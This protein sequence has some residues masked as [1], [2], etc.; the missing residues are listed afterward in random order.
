MPNYA[1]YEYFLSATLLVSA[2]FGMGTS[3]TPTDFLAVA[4]SPQ[5]VLLILG[6]QVLLTPLLVMGLAKAFFLPTEIVIGLFVAAALPGGLFSNIYTFLGKGNVAL[7]VAATALCTL[8]CLFTTTFV[9]RVFAAQ[10]LPDTFQMPTRDILFEIGIC[11]LLPMLA[12]MI[13][14]RWFP[15][16]AASVAKFC[17]RASVVLLL[18]V[19]AAALSGGKIDVTDFGLRVP[20]AIILLQ[21]CL[22]WSSYG[23][24]KLLRLSLNDTFT[25]AIEVLVRNSHLGVLLK[26]ALFPADVAANDAIGGAV[27]YAVLFYGFVCMVV[28]AGEVVGK[29]RFWGVYAKLR[30]LV[31]TEEPSQTAEPQAGR[32]ASQVDE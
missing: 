9:L 6:I 18:L 24:C 26:A 5:N 15:R 13:F 25:V 23:L 27:L 14:R 28:G 3:L 10:H 17:V 31:T 29:L 11:L 16:R 32:A 19:A 12:G 8:A 2:M 7:S 21:V 22:L 30:D 4:R 1:D 20:L